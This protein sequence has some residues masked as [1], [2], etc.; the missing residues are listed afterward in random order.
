MHASLLVAAVTRA[1][2]SAHQSLHISVYFW[3]MGWI[4]DSRF[5]CR[6]SAGYAATAAALG[7]YWFWY[8]Y[9]GSKAGDE[10]TGK[11]KSWVRRNFMDKTPAIW[12]SELRLPDYMQID[13]QL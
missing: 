8:V 7:Y 13:R 3:H 5:Y 10:K 11:K 2:P 12:R 1:F 6:I 4:D 9:A